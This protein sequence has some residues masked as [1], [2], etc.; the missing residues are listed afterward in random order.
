[1]KKFLSILFI[2]NMMFSCSSDDNNTI[3]PDLAG[4]WKLSE[5]NNDPG[6]G[7]GVFIKVKSNKIL[8]FKGN[9]TITSNS[10]LCQNT[11]T[12]DS[13]S[14][15]TY[16]VDTDSPL[17]GT[18]KSPACDNQEIQFEIQGST[19]YVYYSCIEGCTAKY[20]KK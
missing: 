15:G 11:I 18:I 8:T 1:M 13:P 19:L 4:T 16:E 7:S 10:S 20:I 9:N 14:S 5:V 2:A 12:S 17:K 6:D 3:N